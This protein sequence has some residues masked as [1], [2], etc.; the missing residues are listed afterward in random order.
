MVIAHQTKQHIGWKNQG[1]SA[2]DEAVKVHKGPLPY[3]CIWAA[4][5]QPLHMS[6]VMTSLVPKA[7]HARLIS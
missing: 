2:F 7:T 1:D 4:G 6:I 3:G 5:Q